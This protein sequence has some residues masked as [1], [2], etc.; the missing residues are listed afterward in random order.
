MT[1]RLNILKQIAAI[2]GDDMMGGTEEERQAATVLRALHT[3]LALGRV[4]G[5][6][7]VVTPW[8]NGELVAGLQAAELDDQAREDAIAAARVEP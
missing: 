6:A 1:G 2:Y 4:D 7:R 5:L 3:A 8:M